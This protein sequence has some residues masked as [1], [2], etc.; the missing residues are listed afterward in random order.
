VLKRA[1]DV[2]ASFIGLLLICPFYPL[3]A[4]AIKLD[5]LGPVFFTQARVGLNGVSFRIIKLRTMVQD[6]EGQRPITMK[7]DP[8]LTRVGRWLRRRKLDELPSLFNVLRGDMSIVGPRPELERY[9][10]PYTQDQRRILAVRPGITD[11]GTLRFDNETDL[12]ADSDRIEEVY[13]EQILPE[14]IRLNLEYVDKRSF[15]FDLR[16]IFETL[17]LIVSRKRG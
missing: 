8:R 14:K 16:I 7:E 13:L 9:V 12:L 17:F 3:V 15:F 4:L 6:A 5:S 2:V 10:S 11:L 1:F